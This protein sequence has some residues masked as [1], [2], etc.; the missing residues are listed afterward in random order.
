RLGKGKAYYDRFFQACAAP[1]VGLCPK[2]ALHRRLPFGSR[3][4]PMDYVV[5]EH[6]TLRCR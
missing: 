4:I 2:G 1:R 5:C 6:R 3:D